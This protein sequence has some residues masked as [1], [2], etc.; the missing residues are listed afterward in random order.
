MLLLY[1]RAGTDRLLLEQKV[2]QEA[3]VGFARVEFGAEGAVA[4]DFVDGRLEQ[5]I[6]S[7][8]VVVAR[9]DHR[10][11]MA[12]GPEQLLP[13]TDRGK[14]DECRCV[15]LERDPFHDWNDAQDRS[16]TERQDQG[17]DGNDDRTFVRTRQASKCER[18]RQQCQPA[19]VGARSL[20]KVFRMD[21]SR[22]I[23]LASQRR[24]EIT[25]KRQREQRELAKCRCK[26]FD[27]RVSNMTAHEQNRER[28]EL[29]AEVFQRTYGLQSV[30]LR[31]YNVFG[32]RQDPDGAYAAVIP[33]WVSNLLNGEP[34]DI[35]G[36]GGFI[37]FSS[38]V[39]C[40]DL[41]VTTCAGPARTLVSQTAWRLRRPPYQSNC[42]NKPGPCQQL[43]TSSAALR[44]L[45]VDSGRVLLLRPGGTLEV[46]NANGAPVRTFANSAVTGAELMGG[47]L[48]MLMPGNIREYK[49]QTGAL[50]RTRPLPNVTSAG[51]CGMPPCPV[52]ALRLVDAKRGLVAYIQSGRLHLLRLRDGR[53]RIVHR[54]TDARFGDDGLF[55]AFSGAAPWVSRIRFVPWR[56]LPLQP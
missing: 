20:I 51:V 13:R 6:L 21:D 3:F 50:V 16:C 27:A 37:A 17:D 40:G 25:G 41:G 30:G 48:L 2:H 46:M 39:K 15:I 1:V 56:A 34:C 12:R 10:Q 35:Y 36:D 31:Y 45:S 9:D 53:N 26:L 29:Y 43:E 28:H 4:E 24:P 47:R 7:E 33:R 38:R 23:E 32:R 14:D 52:V 22:Q 11:R 44:P 8:R 54:A 49:I 55:Y 18:D 42:V 5:Q 19:D